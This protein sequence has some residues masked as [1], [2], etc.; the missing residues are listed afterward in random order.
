[1]IVAISDRELVMVWNYLTHGSNWGGGE[2]MLLAQGELWD[3]F[4]L[5]G[6]RFKAIFDGKAIDLA[7]LDEKP[8][9]H[10]LS[11]PAIALLRQI[12]AVQG[13]ESLVGRNSRT[14][15]MRIAAEAKAD[16]Q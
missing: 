10:E 1:V 2:E 12:L 5:G 6:G 13:Q 3:A 7:T 14:A 16:E 4:D 15:L 9:P 11:A 8:K